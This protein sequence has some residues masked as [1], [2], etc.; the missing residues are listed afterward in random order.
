MNYLLS[1]SVEILHIVHPYIEQFRPE[2]QLAEPMREAIFE[3]YVYE[4]GQVQHI[5]LSKIQT[6]YT[7]CSSFTTGT[8]TP[9]K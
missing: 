6:Q 8:E 4:L 9:Q 3:R 1:E 5:A 2:R 7:M